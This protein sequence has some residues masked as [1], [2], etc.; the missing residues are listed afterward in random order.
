MRIAFHADLT[1]NQA[2][3]LWRCRDELSRLGINLFDGIS[4]NAPAD[5]HVVHSAIPGFESVIEPLLAGD[6]PVAILE[7]I[8]G[9]QLTGAVRKYLS[10]PNLVVVIKNTVYEDIRKYNSSCWRGHEWACRQ[11]MGETGTEP[12]LPERKWI[13]EADYAKLKVGFSFAAYEHMRPLVESPYSGGDRPYLLNFAGTVDYGPD[14][15]WLNWHRQRCVEAIRAIPGNHFCEVG[16][17]LS[18]EE[19]WDSLRK[20]IF[21][22]SPWGLGEP[23]WRDFEGVL[24]GC[25]VIKPDTKYMNTY[26]RAFYRYSIVSCRPDFSDLAQCVASRGPHHSGFD[27]MR[28]LD[29]HERLNVSIPEMIALVKGGS[30]DM[31]KESSSTEAVAA[32][33]ADIFQSCFCQNAANSP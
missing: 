2:A 22:V 7:R 24:C 6:A 11:A 9:G 20:S 5:A 21:C 8:D 26:P 27:L 1:H 3:V 10:H 19:Y 31:V 28:M 18:R 14:M 23:C 29:E 33:M 13:S 15:P 17:P 32:R 12:M 4:S 30:A 25:V 16:R